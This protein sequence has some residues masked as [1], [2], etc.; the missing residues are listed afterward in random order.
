MKIMLQQLPCSKITKLSGLST[1]TRNEAQFIVAHV[2]CQPEL[3]KSIINI[4]GV[5]ASH[6]FSAI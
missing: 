4:H 2:P 1:H 6:D 5:V 3:P